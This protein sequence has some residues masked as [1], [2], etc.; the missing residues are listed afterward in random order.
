MSI[1]EEDVVINRDGRLGAVAGDPGR[2]EAFLPSP[3]VQNHAANLMP[4]RNGDLACVWFGGTQEGMSDISIYFSRLPPGSAQWS[5]AVKLSDDPSR[6]EQNPVLFPAPDGKLWLLWTA[7]KAGNQDTAFVRRRISEDDGHSWGPIEV[8]FGVAGEGC[9]TFIRQ[10]IVVLDNGE[11]LLPVFY[12]RAKP[13]RKWTGEDDT[14]SVKISA[15]QGR[16]WTDY[17]VPDSAGLVHMNVEQLT[18]GSLLALFRSRWADHIYQSRSHDGGRT[19]EPPVPAGLPNNNSSIQFT[20]LT[21]GHLALVFNDIRADQNTERRASLYDEIEDDDGREEPSGEPVGR[22]AFWGTP[23]APMTIA[24]SED[25]GKTWAR[26]RN[27]ETGS[28]YCLTNNSVEGRNREFSYP[29]VK[30]TADGAIHVAFTYWRQA[31]KH[32]RIHEDWVNG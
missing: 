30:Q 29:S 22:T 12:C 20:R 14:S 7:Q 16:T 11:W 26:K 17:A 31:I 3:C 6:S 23:R 32:V 2:A 4:L 25:E 27:V 13:G 1:T 28:G 9:G 24:I 21:N 15:D 10:P 8:L 5:P 19:W 18:D